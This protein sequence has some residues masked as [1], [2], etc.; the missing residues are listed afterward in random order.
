LLI[1]D[2][3][4]KSLTALDLDGTLMGRE[5]TISRRVR[6]AVKQAIDQ[7]H[8]VTI[9]TGRGYAPTARFAQDLGVNA[10]IIC[11]QGAL[12]RDYRD[13]KIVHSATIPLPIARALIVFSQAR[14]LNFQVYTQDDQAYVS[15]MDPVAEGIAE[16]SGIPVT[17]VKDLAGWLN[18]PPIKFMFFEQEE[19]VPELVRD[20]KA[21]FDG[22][23]QVVRSW[24][25]LIEATGPSISKGEALARLAAHVGVARSETMA[26][27]DQDNDVSMIAWAGLGVAMGNASP[28]A[29]AAADVIAP[30]LE[31]DGAAWAIERYVLGEEDIGDVADKYPGR[32]G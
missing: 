30:A 6:H 12:I 3:T 16:L 4:E 17:A 5:R 8:L 21:Q 20:I 23:L 11:Y 31:A 26:I 1:D 22:H 29:K 24:D 19:A 14:E 15:Q 9:A 28:A 25:R 32:A 13:G 10:P 27:G 7:G 2:R 18:R